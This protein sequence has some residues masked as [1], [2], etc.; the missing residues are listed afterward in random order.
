MSELDII[1]DNEDNNNFYL[2]ENYD[3]FMIDNQDI[4]NAKREIR[5]YFIANYNKNIFINLAFL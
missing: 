3:F 4:F 5:P 1:I 2:K